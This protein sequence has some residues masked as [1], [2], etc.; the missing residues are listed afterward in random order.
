MNQLIETGDFEVGPWRVRPSRSEVEAEG[1][2]VRLEPRVMGVLVALARRPGATVAR[3][4]LIEEVWAGRVVTDDAV[5]RCIAALRKVLRSRPGADIETIPKLGYALRVAVEPAAARETPRESGSGW[6]ARL[7]AWPAITLALAALLIAV[8]W[9]M[10]ADI[11]ASSQVS[12]SVPRARPL[13]ALPGREVQPALSPSGGQVAF[14]WSGQDGSNS[15]IYVKTV[16]GEG[17]LRLTDDPATDLRPTWSADGG[18]IAFVRVTGGRC[19]LFSASALGGTARRIADCGTGQVR[20]LDWSPDGTTFALASADDDLAPARLKLI[21]ARTG[22]AR[23]VSTIDALQA[24]I[25][26]ARFSP[27]AQQLAFAVSRALGVEDV[28]VYRFEDRSLRRLTFDRLKIH[29]L[30]WSAAGDAVVFSSN[31]GGPFRLW[32]VPVAGGEPTLVPGAGDAAD[33][34][35]VAASGRIAYEVW[36]EDA[37]LVSFDLGN[38]ATEPRALASSTRFEWDAKVS[39]DGSRI[40]FVSD[41][42]GAAEVW[43]AARDGAEPQRLTSFAGPYTHSPRWSPDGTRLAF[44]SP[45]SGRMNLFV[46]SPG[47]ASPRRIGTEDTDYL[48]PVWAADGTSLFVGG[49]RVQADTRD[50]AIWRV[51][52]DAGVPLRT[53]T[54]GARTAQLSADGSQLYYTKVGEAG[55]W[56]RSLAGAG[57]EERVISDLTPVDWNNW[58]VTRAAIYYVRRPAETSPELVRF[59]LQSGT[60][61]TVRPLPGLLYKSGLWISPDERELIATVV[62]RA[63][64]D[65][66][67]LE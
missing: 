7:F 31:R 49:T 33:D 8:L 29:N 15:D 6:T 3:D 45:V 55:L 9:W 2:S 38:P 58:V 47:D 32:Q 14:V 48:A 61:R 37:E 40:A 53:D 56:R 62:V 43:I 35:S 54:A 27:D 46:M 57:G 17:L 44:V 51:P 25:E 50:H 65:L 18:E 42:S 5:Q 19:T 64:S 59:D 60:T 16:N 34:P 1:R 36:R 67:L 63:E 30:D 21:D 24:G 66:E 13:T 28:H 23:A 12:G 26:D 39:P 41:R 52:V 22:E 20:S 4:R 11:P 10:S